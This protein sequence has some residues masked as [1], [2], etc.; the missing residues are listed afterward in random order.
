MKPKLQDTWAKVE[1]HA[2]II[3]KKLYKT[4]YNKKGRK[5]VQENKN[6]N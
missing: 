6:K 3:L 5:L 4:D 1:K 2:K